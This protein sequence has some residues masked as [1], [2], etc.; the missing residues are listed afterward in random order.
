MAAIRKAKVVWTG[1]LAKGSGTVTA[2]SSGAFDGL[3]VTWASRVEKPD[4]RTSPEELLGAAHASCFC[5]ALSHALGCAG[6]P[7]QLL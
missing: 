4:G 7:P 5:M 1:D 6:T 3:A 2:A